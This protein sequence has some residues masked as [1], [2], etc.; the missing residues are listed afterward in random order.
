MIIFSKQHRGFTLIEMVT[1]VFI[2]LII[3]SLFIANY[4]SANKRTDLVMSAQQLV[5]DIHYTQNNTLGLVKYNSAVPAGGWG[6]HFET[7]T[8]TYKIFADLDAPGEAGYMQFSADEGLVNYGARVVDL[9]SNVEFL[10]LTTGLSETPTANVTFLPPD[11]Q[12][13]IYD[14]SGTSTV[15]NI[16]LKD[17]RNSSIKTIR[18]NFLGLAEVLD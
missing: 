3:A 10:S 7:G 13:N 17:K 11:P 5:S 4:R 1:S 18:V 8:S 16:V 6:I 2:I 9:G 15:L 14:G 12:T